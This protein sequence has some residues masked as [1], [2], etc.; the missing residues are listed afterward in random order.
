MLILAVIIFLA[1]QVLGT[2][3]R[4]GHSGEVITLGLLAGQCRSC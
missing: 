4:H 1:S 2:V 3:A